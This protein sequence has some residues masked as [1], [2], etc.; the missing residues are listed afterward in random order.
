MTAATSRN[1]CCLPKR[2][3][4]R[5][6]LTRSP[7]LSCASARAAD[8]RTLAGSA[9][10]PSCA[11]LLAGKQVD[12]FL[13]AYRDFEPYD[14]SFPELAA[15]TS[16]RR[17]GGGGA[18]AHVDAAKRL[19]HRDGDYANTRS[20]IFKPRAS[21]ANP[22][23]GGSWHTASKKYGWRSHGSR[24]RR[25]SRRDRRGIDPRSPAQRCRLLAAAS[26]SEQYLKL[27]AKLSEARA[28]AR[29]MPRQSTKTNR[30]DQ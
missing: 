14:K 17:S 6:P 4:R 25:S 2:R 28:G 22:R 18:L 23:A 5:F 13:A 10:G 24:R 19:R 9:R 8:A 7:K 30:R 16:C 20:A 1:A 29:G 21:G 11:L 26:A 27:T 12:A 3:R 15:A